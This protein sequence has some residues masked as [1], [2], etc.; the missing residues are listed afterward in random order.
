MVSLLKESDINFKSDQ[1]YQLT[2]DN[3]HLVFDFKNVAEVYLGKPKETPY[4]SIE[5]E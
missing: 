2:L 1:V 3:Q 5:M 4:I